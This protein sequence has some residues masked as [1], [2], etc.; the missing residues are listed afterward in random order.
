MDKT[1]T[2][3]QK[4]GSKQPKNKKKQQQQQQ[5]LKVVYITNPIKFNATAS[6]FRALV[7]ELTGQDANVE[8]YSKFAAAEGVGGGEGVA[9]EQKDDGLI[10]SPEM[11]DNFQGL[12]FSSHGDVYVDDVFKN[13]GC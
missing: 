9:A 4:R 2:Q 5:P 10:G 1:L 6:E 13:L 11:I 12:A 7:Q 3:N 8:D